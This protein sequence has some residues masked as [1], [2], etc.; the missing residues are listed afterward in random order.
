MSISKMSRDGDG[1]KG[2]ENLT[3]FQVYVCRWR[4]VPPEIAPLIGGNL[5]P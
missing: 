1:M 2:G 5:I 4:E 3:P